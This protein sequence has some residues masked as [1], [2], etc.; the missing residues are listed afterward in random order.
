[1]SLAAPAAGTAPPTVQRLKSL[2]KQLAAKHKRLNNLVGEARIAAAVEQAV[3]PPRAENRAMRA[4]LARL[5]ECV[6]SQHTE[7]MRVASGSAAML[8]RLENRSDPELDML[9]A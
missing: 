1:M 7:Q 2:L 5:Q 6:R 3:A 9:A 4:E 8:Q